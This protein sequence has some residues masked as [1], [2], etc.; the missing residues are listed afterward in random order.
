MA[1][2]QTIPAECVILIVSYGSIFE[3][4]RMEKVSK[5]FRTLFIENN[6]YQSIIYDAN[7]L[8]LTH[9]PIPYD[10]NSTGADGKKVQFEVQFRSARDF[11]ISMANAFKYGKVSNLLR[12]TIAVS[13]LDRAL[14]LPDNIIAPICPGLQFHPNEPLTQTDHI[15]GF[16]RQRRC[17]C[18]GPRPCYW[19]SGPSPRPDGM[20]F[21]TCLLDSS[22]CCV[23]SFG[24][25]PYRAYFHPNAPTYAP[26]EVAIQFLLPLNTPNRM[27]EIYGDEYRD[28]VRSV[29]RIDENGTQFVMEGTRRYVHPLRKQYL[30]RLLQADMQTTDDQAVGN[31]KET[32]ILLM[33]GIETDK[34]VYYQSP[35]FEV[36]NEARPQ[37]FALPHPILNI[38]GAI[39][40]VFRGYHQVQDLGGPEEGWPDVEKAYYMCV[41]NAAVFGFRLDK[42]S[43]VVKTQEIRW[44]SEL[45]NGK[46]GLKRV[47]CVFSSNV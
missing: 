20:E 9:L 26:R 34:Y 42:G 6:T 39:R 16:T 35:F 8:R 4:F 2:F 40:Y 22:F 21:I 11:V 15:Q 33:E 18:A 47:K 28:F 25:A 13:S 17:G 27:E 46:T 23:A 36:K 1:T 44:S 7:L 30:H 10:P 5:Y 12:K 19:G 31:D 3:V 37:I 24:I 29:V 38:G 32:P 43:N 14:E 45:E 41:A